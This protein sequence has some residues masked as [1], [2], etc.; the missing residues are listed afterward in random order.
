[1]LLR[2][3]GPD[4]SDK[5]RGELEGEADAVSTHQRTPSPLADA[6]GVV[7][8]LFAFPDQERRKKQRRHTHGLV[9]GGFDEE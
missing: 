8:S 9:G 5:P 6:G 2:E 7:T 4:E 1:L 3:V